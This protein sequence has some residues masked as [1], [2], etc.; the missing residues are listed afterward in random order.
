MVS[1]IL[2]HKL[3]TYIEGLQFVNVDQKEL[4]LLLGEFSHDLGLI[5]H[6]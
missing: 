2:P 5:M 6:T 3:A 1:S 4:I